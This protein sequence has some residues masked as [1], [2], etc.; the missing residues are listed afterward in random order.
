MNVPEL[1]RIHGNHLVNIS[2]SLCL[3][4]LYHP[5][6]TRTFHCKDPRK[7]TTGKF[8]WKQDID[9]LGLHWDEVYSN[10]RRRVNNNIYKSGVNVKSVLLNGD[11]ASEIKLDN[12]EI[13]KFDLVIF[14]DGINSIGRPLLS[15]NSTLNY[16]GYVAW[17]GVLDF[18]KI[19]DKTP[20]IN[21]IPY[22]CYDNGHLLA[23]A[24]NHG[25]EKKLNWVFYEKLSL[26]KLKQLEELQKW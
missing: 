4:Y 15:Q 26:E 14:S 22:Y 12:G 6:S 25:G 5:A 9:V 7:P 8:I 21:N 20:F 23:Y 18:S 19:Q 3:V 2:L 11:N 10:L 24:V 17:R 13:L 1:S 16:S